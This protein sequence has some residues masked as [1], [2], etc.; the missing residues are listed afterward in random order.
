MTKVSKILSILLLLITV[1]PVIVFGKFHNEFLR[2]NIMFAS[3]IF[4]YFAN[5]HYLIR[6]VAI[7]VHIV[8]ILSLDY[9]YLREYIMQL[10]C[11]VKGKS[12]RNL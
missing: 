1:T 3:I 12:N 8:V 5:E 6:L 7:V 11:Y 10:A 9:L 2:L 4:T